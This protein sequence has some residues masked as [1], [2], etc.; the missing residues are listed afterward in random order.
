MYQREYGA[1]VIYDDKLFG[2]WKGMS[3]AR[4][5]MSL[6][7]ALRRQRQVDLSLRPA[8]SIE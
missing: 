5:P 4:L 8:W 3:Q 2:P 6:I 1:M 7:P